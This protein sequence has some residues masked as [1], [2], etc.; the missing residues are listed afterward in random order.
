MLNF[1]KITAEKL[2]NAIAE[3]SPD[4]ALTAEEIAG[5]L[6]YPPDAAMGDIA[7]P[8]FRLSKAMRK[9][10]PMIAAALAEKLTGGEFESVT[11]AGAYINFKV[12]KGYLTKNVLLA[13][14]EKG[15]K[16]GSTN[17]GEGKT[18]VLDYCS[19]NLMKPFHIGHL[20]TTVI[21]HSLKL[22]HEFAGYKCV[23][24]NYLGDWGTQFGKQIAA[25]KKWGDRETIEKGGVDELVK[26]YVRYNNECEDNDALKDE[27][28]AEFRK[29]EE[30]DEENLALWKWFVDVSF[31]ECRKTCDLLGV[32]FD[33]FKG[34]SFYTD[35][36]P[37]QVEK[38]RA[39]GLLRIDEGASIVDLSDYNMPPCLILKKDGTTLYPTRDIAAAVY[40]KNTYDF[41]KAI[42]VTSSAQSLHFAQWFKVVELM[43][44]DWSD[45]LVHVPYGTVSIG[46]AKLATRTG[47]VVLLKDL[48]RQSIE[49]VTEIMNEKNP[50]L[51]NKEETAEA[52]GVGAI[53]F[54]YLFNSRIK[55]INF[56]LES[57]LS[58]E[59]N[60][61]PYAQYT[62]A[63]CC[64]IVAKAKEAGMGASADT[65]TH[66]DEAAL[67]KT[68]AKFPERVQQAIAEYEPSDIT[69]YIIDVCTAFNR[70]YCN[71]PIMNAEDEAVRAMRVRL[72]SA[73]KTVL[74]TA[75]HLICMKTPE[76]I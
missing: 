65:V 59:G 51:E 15:E 12:S 16:Y 56:T 45:K 11:T 61:G 27:A 6:E 69:R 71:C 39:L 33:S 20:G 8:C 23:G 26:L 31:E 7:F 25:Y 48:F 21:G 75:L 36:M 47:N 74:G 32:T 60:T 64:S 24:I 30:G 57:A 73:T 4:A 38:L 63:R 49:K 50:N 9:A 54:N 68:L 17:E 41:E 35:K 2:A 34:E 3:L 13:I 37:A 46:G 40:R 58:F 18:V 44:Y 19:P 10:P 14:E 43:G 28:R 53:V 5:L 42:Y 22:L 67:L 29:L 72:T 62:Y 66:E 70:F 55:D 1:K 76:K 52:V